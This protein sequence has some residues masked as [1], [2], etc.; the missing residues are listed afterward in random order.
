[1][2]KKMSWREI[3]K[4]YPEQFVLLAHCEE[5]LKNT[6][7]VVITSGEVILTSSDGKK[8]Y[9]EYCKQ[10]QPDH[11]TFGHTHSMSLEMESVSYL[12]IRPQYE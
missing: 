5:K 1:M 2:V 4:K 12:G 7:R 10:G 8:I 9:D 3:R 11:M 6:H